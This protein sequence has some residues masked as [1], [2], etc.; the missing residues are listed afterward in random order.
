MSQL[1][2]RSVL[3]LCVTARFYLENKGKYILEAWGHDDPND[4]K[5][6]SGRD[7]EHPP[8]PRHLAPLFICFFLL[9]LDLPYV[10]WASQ[11]CCLFYLRSSLPSLPLIYFLGLFPSL[12]FSHGHSGLLFPILTWPSISHKHELG[13]KHVF[14]SSIIP[15]L[16]ML[17]LFWTLHVLISKMCNARVAS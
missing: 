11:E 6:E 9:L 13:Q 3:Q 12:S 14:H 17:F 7:R 16:S 8:F 4:V 5:G 10:I 15:I 2:D 1:S